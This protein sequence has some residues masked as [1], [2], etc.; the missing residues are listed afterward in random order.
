[1]EIINILE[2]EFFA[3]EAP[4]GD[5]KRGPGGDDRGLPRVHLCGQH[6]RPKAISEIAKKKPFSL[7]RLSVQ[8]VRN[9]IEEQEDI[10]KKS[11]LEALLNDLRELVAL[12]EGRLPEAS[13]D[14]DT[15]AETA[16]SAPPAP[17]KKKPKIA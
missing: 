3:S 1:M 9:G 6:R 10:F 13:E 12:V 4:G 8:S 15:T 14:G 17:I 5:P 2:K 16:A 7:F 11:D